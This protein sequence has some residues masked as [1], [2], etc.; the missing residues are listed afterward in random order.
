MENIIGKG[1][2]SI[3]LWGKLD[4]YVAKVEYR[5]E[6]IATMEI[7]T[8]IQGGAMIILNARA[9][10]MRYA[11]DIRRDYWGQTTSSRYYTTQKRKSS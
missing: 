10:D 2:I 3:A 11:T 5:T 6:R 1:G 9:P 8:K 7:R 4:Q